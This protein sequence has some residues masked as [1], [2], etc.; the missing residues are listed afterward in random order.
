VGSVEV[1]LRDGSTLRLRLGTPADADE[2]LAGF[3]ELSDESRYRRFFTAKPQLTEATFE[4]LTHV[5]RE[6]HVAIGAFDP[7]TPSSVGGADG[8]GVGVARVIRDGDQPESAEFA[9]AVIDPYQRRGIGH[10]LL[11]AALVVSDRLGVRWL[12]GTVLAE[13]QPMRRLAM[14]L[15]AERTP[16]ADPG[17]LEYTFDVPAVVGALDSERRRAFA[18][19][20]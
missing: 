3:K 4:Q 15:G 20:L 17:M 19:L 12:R 7:A 13:N 16:N 8:I 14:A 10:E 6:H 9:I 2:L 18:V 1:T 11:Q 5:D